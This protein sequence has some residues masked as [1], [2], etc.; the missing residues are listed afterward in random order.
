M[1][2]IVILL[3]NV[4]EMGNTEPDQH[5]RE[6]SQKRT[7]RDQTVSGSHGVSPFQPYN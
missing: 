6:Q 7:K 4:K 5:H 3:A 1:L 2:A